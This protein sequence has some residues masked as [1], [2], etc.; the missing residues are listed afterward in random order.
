MFWFISFIISVFILGTLMFFSYPQKRERAD[1][2]TY[3]DKS[4]WV[5]EDEGRILVPVWMVIVA[6][7]V[8][9][10]PVV[11]LICSAVVVI[12]YC[13]Q[14]RGECGMDGYNPVDYRVELRAPYLKWVKWLSKKI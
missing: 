13:V 5:D 9:I 8:S 2:V 1:D 6:G 12:M 11:N 10:I 7:I 4:P 3:W 14:Y